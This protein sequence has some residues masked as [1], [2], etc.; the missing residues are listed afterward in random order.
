MKTT[1]E[2][3]ELTDGGILTYYPE[4][5][6]ESIADKLFLVLK[7]DVSWKQEKTFYGNVFPRLTA[8]FSDIGVTYAYSGVSHESNPWPWYLKE[9]KERVEKQA[10]G[11]F[12]SLLLNYYRNGKD[13]IGWHS[14]DEREL[15][16]N[17]IV[18]SLSFGSERV[19]QIRHKK[20]REKK[21]YLLKHGSLLVMS[22]TMQH[23][24]QHSV[25]KTTKV[26]DPR[27]NLTFRN[28]KYI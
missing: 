26:N 8:Y 3:T 10:D 14:D 9:V 1:I 24:W 4:F 18:P 16:K 27:I 13:S 20:T 25:P 2:K 19:F 23:Y 6:K 17:P 22:G 15:G 21:E 28:I 11:I 12:N 5:F 7:R